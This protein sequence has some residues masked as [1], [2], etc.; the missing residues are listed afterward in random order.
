M[1]Q[2]RGGRGKNGVLGSLPSYKGDIRTSVRFHVYCKSDLL[3]NPHHVLGYLRQV[4]H[5]FII[6]RQVC[7]PA[8]RR[9]LEMASLVA[10][11]MGSPGEKEVPAEAALG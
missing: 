4:T 11:A 8:L 10:R 7:V 1:K 2:R 5:K 6:L 3:G 9:W